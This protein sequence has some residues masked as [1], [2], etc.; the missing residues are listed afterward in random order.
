MITKQAR[1]SRARRSSIELSNIISERRCE[2]KANEPVRNE[3]TRERG[4]CRIISVERAI[5]RSYWYYPQYPI[6]LLSIIMCVCVCVCV[7]MCVCVCVCVFVCVCVCECVAGGFNQCG[8]GCQ[9][10]SMNY[11]VQ[12][13]IATS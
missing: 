7:C 9:E 12:A 2:L 5:A 8:G 6:L 1:R 10:R 13:C 11:Q 3:V 4:C